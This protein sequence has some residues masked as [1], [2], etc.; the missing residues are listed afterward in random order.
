MKRN[1]L[2]ALVTVALMATPL[3][4]ASANGFISNLDLVT[5]TSGGSVTYWEDVLNDADYDIDEVSTYPSESNYLENVAAWGVDPTENDSA[6]WEPLWD[7]RNGDAFDS[8]GEVWAVIE[9]E[10][11]EIDPASCTFGGD[12]GSSEYPASVISDA[13]IYCTSNDV[14]FAGGTVSSKVRMTFEEN[15]VKYEIEAKANA[16]LVA[17]FVVGGDLGSDEDTYFNT[18]VDNGTFWVTSEDEP[19][20]SGDD[21]IIAYRTNT[22]AD[23]L[24]ASNGDPASNEEEDVYFRMKNAVTLTNEYQPVFTIEVALFGFADEAKATAVE[25]ALDIIQENAFGTP[26][27]Y[28]SSASQSCAL[29]P[30]GGPV[31]VTPATPFVGQPSGRYVAN[32]QSFDFEG[33]LL[34]QVKSIT[35]DDIEVKIDL[36]TSNRAS[37][38]VP[39]SLPAGP[40]TCVFDFPGQSITVANAFQVQGE[41]GAVLLKTTPKTI[42]VEINNAIGTRVAIRVDGKLVRVVKPG[43]VMR[44]VK[45]RNLSPNNKVL[46]VRIDGERVLRQKLNR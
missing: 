8:W 25:C 24:D 46:V 16:S 5:G 45:V 23:A 33:V 34:D 43:K 6:V 44:V 29:V 32:G 31:S 27:P 18:P 3:T 41:S 37:I 12:Y 22:P 40:V 14:V 30:A 36:Q 17:K 19:A 13:S 7:S 1:T 28:F 38:V 2:A 20:N 35:C 42:T 39:D 11:L 26:T 15:W 9:G 21:P 4:S 10:N